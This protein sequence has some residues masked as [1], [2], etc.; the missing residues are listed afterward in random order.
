MPWVHDVVLT[1]DLT[2][3]LIGT[4][5][6]KRCDCRHLYKQFEWM[7]A[8]DPRITGSRNCS[9]Y[10][11]V[12]DKIV[13]DDGS[14]F[15]AH[16]KCTFAY[17]SG[18]K[19]VTVPG[20]RRGDSETQRLRIECTV[21]DSVRREL[22]RQAIPAAVFDLTT[23]AKP[24][25]F[26]ETERFLVAQR[27]FDSKSVVSK[28]PQR[29][30]NI[31]LCTTV[32]RFELMVMAEWLVFHIQRGIEHIF[33]YDETKDGS[34]CRQVK[35]FIDAGYITCVYY[36]YDSCGAQRRTRQFLIDDVAYRFPSRINQY[37]ALDSCYNRFSQFTTWMG[38]WDVD[39][40]AVPVGGHRSYADVLA[41]YNSDNRVAGVGL[42]MDWVR[43]P[44][45]CNDPWKGK[46]SSGVN[47]PCNETELPH[48]G[49]WCLRMYGAKAGT[50]GKCFF[51]TS[52]ALMTWVHYLVA[53]ESGTRL[54]MFDRK[55]EIYLQHVRLWDPSHEKI[56]YMMPS[57][58]CRSF[59][60]DTSTAPYLED[61]RRGIKEW[62]PDINMEPQK[63]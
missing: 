24:G 61:L 20:F 36:P 8:I 37:S 58:F 51:K 54:E 11:Y 41:K 40:F 30:Y 47:Q 42:V 17:P 6:R 18:R 53:A 10:V 62:Y 49:S 9:E 4:E 1:E 52:L 56:R 34:I 35:R 33:L 27:A 43:P 12:D 55:G 3:V 28:F 57:P 32:T 31:A 46:K 14:L 26:N 44:S 59:W 2:T 60:V 23:S 39:E 63:E 38:I 19:P 48:M 7:K 25:S 16:Y 5:S 50:D 29:K 22:S 21:P 45:A 13:S 15:K